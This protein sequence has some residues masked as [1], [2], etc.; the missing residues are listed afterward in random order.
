MHNLETWG[1]LRLFLLVSSWAVFGARF[2]S[3]LPKNTTFRYSISTIPLQ[4][5]ASRWLNRKHVFQIPFFLGFFLFVSFFL[6]PCLA[7]REQWR[8]DVPVLSPTLQHSPITAQSRVFS[9]LGPLPQSVPLGVSGQ[10]NACECWSNRCQDVE[11]RAGDSWV[12][13]TCL[14][15]QGENALKC[16]TCGCTPFKAD[17]RFCKSKALRRLFSQIKPFVA[18]MATWEVSDFRHSKQLRLAI[19][20]KTR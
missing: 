17:H 13:V 5:N 18:H 20:Q 2:P 9:Q 11:Q 15:Q 7:H 10:E 14:V 6:C 4:R 16:H 19:P 1:G 12:L 3:K 8:A